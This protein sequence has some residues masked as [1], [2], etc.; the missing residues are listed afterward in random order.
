VFEQL[1]EKFQKIFHNLRGYGKLTEENVA[2][3]LREIRQALLAADVPFRVVGEFLERVKAASLGQDVA[4]SITPGQMMVKVVHDEMVRLLGESESE[5]T[6]SGAPGVILLAG[7]QGSGKTT[8][9][10][11]L[12]KKLL[13]KGKKVLLVACDTV[14]PAAA[15]QLEILG[16]QA[17]LATFRDA[18][19]TDPVAL[20]QKAL[21]K[22]REE[23]CDILVVDTAGRLHLDEE[24]L[25]QLACIGKELR[26]AHV[27]LV[28]DAMMGQESLK[29]AEKFHQAMG[30]TGFVVTKLDGDARG[31]VA[32][33]MRAVTQKPIF[34]AG[35]GEKTGDLEPFSPA[36]MASRILGMGDVVGLVEKAQEAFEENQARHL[37]EKVRRSQLD[38]SDLLRQLQMMK[39][40]GPLEN[41]IK[42]IPG[43]DALK[44]LNVSGNELMRAEAIIQS[45][46]LAERISPDILDGSRRK[47]IASGSG[48]SVPEVNRL[49]DRFRQMKKMM[50]QYQQVQRTS[51]RFAGSSGA[52]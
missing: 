50:K 36:R 9:A 15:E 40:M 26:P 31:G 10:A 11:K 44:G 46:T 25:D 34:W 45:M 23:N 3:S 7:L 12:G 17:G 47:R 33:A 4:T 41:L 8:T 16:R 21:E 42:M 38:L 37:Q 28:M 30:V 19:E 20:A 49:L 29:L 24:L 2:A 39:K 35:V 5:F 22:A 27:L 32:L 48:A 14:R 51:G 13:Q 6:I 43:A 1:T 52:K 18:T